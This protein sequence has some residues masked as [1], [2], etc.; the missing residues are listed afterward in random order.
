MVV[1][2]AKHVLKPAG[3]TLGHEWVARE[4]FSGWQESS[5]LLGDLLVC[6][7]FYV[8]M[9]VVNQ[10]G[11]IPFFKKVSIWGFHLIKSFL[12][13]YFMLPFSV[14]LRLIRVRFKEKRWSR[15]HPFKS[16]FEWHIVYWEVMVRV[17]FF[18]LCIKCI[19]CKSA[20]WW[21]ASNGVGSILFPLRRNQS[22]ICNLKVKVD[23]CSCDLKIGCKSGKLS[24]WRC[25][26]PC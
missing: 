15:C 13:S 20:E 16:A 9:S 17:W 11:L 7:V 5:W 4:P 26:C 2:E 14:C 6:L 19:N 18:K 1:Q 22:F 23:P 8:T 24:M 10:C 21:S 3:H 25:V 12:E